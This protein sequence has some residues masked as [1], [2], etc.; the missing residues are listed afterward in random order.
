[1]NHSQSSQVACILTLSLRSTAATLF[2]KAS[3][4]WLPCCIMF[5]SLLAVS[6]RL[7]R[8]RRRYWLLMISS[9]VSL[10]CISLWN[11]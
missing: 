6:V 4:R 2:C 3:Q 9:C 7:S 5:R 8:A 1:M 11:I 10:S